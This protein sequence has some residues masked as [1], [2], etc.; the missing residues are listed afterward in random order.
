MP[1]DTFPT[2]IIKRLH[3]EY[4]RYSLRF[5]LVLVVHGGRNVHMCADAL[6][7]QRCQV[8]WS[9]RCREFWATWWGLRFRLR[10][11][12]RIGEVSLFLHA[13]L[14]PQNTERAWTRSRNRENTNSSVQHCKVNKNTLAF[15]TKTA[16]TLDSQIT[17]VLYVLGIEPQVSCMPGK[18]PYS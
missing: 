18:C 16:P 14:L 11:S 13:W 15:I 1:K 2:Q 7:G 10:S 5:T 8:P 9:W 17:S 6:R 12:Q 4:I 3:K